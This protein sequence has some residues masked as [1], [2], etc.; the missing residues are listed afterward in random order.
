M[1]LSNC[2]GTIDETYRGEVFAVFYHVIPG[3]PRYNV[4]DRIGQIKLG[5][6]LAIEFEE[7]DELSDTDRGAGGYG[8]TGR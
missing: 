5:V 6:T 3:L 1:V 2:E 8:S 4:G 7:A